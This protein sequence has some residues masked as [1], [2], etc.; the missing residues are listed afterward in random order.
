M[1]F[2]GSK[3]LPSIDRCNTIF[4]INFM[5]LSML[6]TICLLIARCVNSVLT[7]EYIVLIDGVSRCV[8]RPS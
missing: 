5:I 4:N 6:I 2:I 1:V 8:N 3:S 7:R